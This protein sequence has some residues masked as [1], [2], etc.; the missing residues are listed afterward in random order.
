MHILLEVATAGLVVIPLFAVGRAYRETHSPR[1]LLAFAAF[2]IFGLRS[3]LI[4]AVHSFFFIDHGLEET[5]DFLTDLI[6][7]G[8]FAAAFLV[9]TRWSRDGTDAELA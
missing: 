6:A 9:S 2:G 3:A 4:L 5:I 7:I 1:L 8:L